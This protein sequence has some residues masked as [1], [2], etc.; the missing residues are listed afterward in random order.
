MSAEAV[1][2][3]FDLQSQC[4]LEELRQVNA[5]ICDTIRFNVKKQQVAAAW[6]FNPGD[7]VYFFTKQGDKVCGTV[8]KICQKNIQLRADSGMKWTVT[9]TLLKKIADNKNMIDEP[10]EENEPNHPLTED[11]V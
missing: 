7:R 2:K 5:F 8:S 4:T 3:M 6:S 1:K 11:P 10:F 9:S